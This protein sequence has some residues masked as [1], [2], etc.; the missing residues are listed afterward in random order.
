MA[1]TTGSTTRP[2]AP[3]VR[4]RTGHRLPLRPVAAAPRP[5]GNQPAPARTGEQADCGGTPRQISGHRELVHHQQRNQHKDL[6]P[7]PIGAPDH[8]SAGRSR[9]LYPGVKRRFERPNDAKTR[10][11]PMR[12]RTVWSLSTTAMATTVVGSASDAP[13]ISPGTHPAV[14]VG[15]SPRGPLPVRRD[16]PRSRRSQA[17]DGRQ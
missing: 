14:A 12:V 1:A 8:C 5:R 9:S 4:P 3:A 16:V 11:R 7:P 6:R 13:G 15:A 10:R 17:Q 2:D